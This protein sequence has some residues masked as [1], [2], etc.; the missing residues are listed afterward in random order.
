MTNPDAV[1]V[2]AADHG[3]VETAAA[4][5][6]ESPMVVDKGGFLPPPFL[7]GI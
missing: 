7:L 6:I 3:L 5:E 4:V 2:G 1:V